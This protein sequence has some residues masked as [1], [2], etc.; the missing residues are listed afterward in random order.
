MILKI[1][2]IKI[3]LYQINFEIPTNKTGSVAKF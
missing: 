3:L 1:L 2:F